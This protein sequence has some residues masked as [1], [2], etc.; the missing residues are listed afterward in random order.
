MGAPQRELRVC[1]LDVSGAPCASAPYCAIA[2]TELTRRRTKKASAPWGEALDFGATSDAALLVVDVWAANAAPSPPTLL[3]KAM[4][5]LSHCRKGVP[6]LVVGKL[7]GGGEL[8]VQA[9]RE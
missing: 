4:L 2:V 3:G 7:L 5:P 9:T 1:V 8:A 6:H